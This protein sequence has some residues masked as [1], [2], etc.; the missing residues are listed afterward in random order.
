MISVSG[1]NWEEITLNKRIIEKVRVDNNLSENI[2]KLV[3][4]RKFDLGEILSINRNINLTNPFINNNDFIICNKILENSLKNNEKIIIIGDYDVD[5]CVSTSLLCN[6]FKKIKKKVNYYIPNRFNDGYGVSLSYIK[7][8]CKK[9]P[10]LIIIVDCGSS[11]QETIKYLNK[12]KIKS[13]I[14]DHHEIYKPYPKSDGLI[15]PKKECDYSNYDYLSAATLTYFFIDSYIK[16]KK[17]NMNFEKNLIYVLL[18]IVC[19]VMPLRK[20]NRL[21]AINVLRNFDINKNFLIKK[22]FELKNIKKPLEVNDLGFLIGPILNS[23]GRIGDASKVVELLTNDN[24]ILKEKII[25]ELLKTNDKRKKIE[26]DSINELNLNEIKKNQ[27]NVLVIYNK[28]LNEGIIGIIASR[29]KEYLNKPCIVLTK[30]G[31]KYKAS[32]RSTPD[33]NIG[34]YIKNA[35]DNNIIIKGGGHNLAAGFLI[36]S[37]NINLFENYINS[38]FSKN[39][40]NTNKIFLSKISLSA[41]NSK[42]LN[43]LKTIGPFGPRNNN[44]FFLLENVK[45]IEPK[46]VNDKFLSFFVKSKFGKSISGIS[47]DYLES[48]LIKNLLNYK[49]ETNLIVK[50]KENHWNNKKKLQLVV[51]DMIQHLNKA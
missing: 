45:I 50:I 14:I 39:K 43:D 4:S 11:A 19:D 48:E 28:I 44:P 42:F 2:S 47:F 13:I 3:I 49:N 29:L 21:I 22:I 35:V 16:T 37:N 5:G 34:K 51:I 23:A 31:N 8:I 26:I 33:F 7:K 25:I 40:V 24:F 15:N 27:N 30:I 41:V 9:N 17:I 32:A 6:F 12:K 1:Y 10:D 38:V 18:S 20:I 46:I 36:N